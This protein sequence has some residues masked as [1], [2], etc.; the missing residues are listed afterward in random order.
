MFG[1][2]DC[3]NFFVSCERLFRPD[4]L[5]KPVAVLSSNDG[6]IVARSQEVKDL[7]IPMGVPYFQVKDVLTKAGATLFSSNFTLYRDISA[8]VMSTLEQEVGLC[9]IYSIDEAF[10]ELPDD[11]TQNEVFAIRTAVMNKVGIPVSIG[12]AATKTLAKQGS[13]L[14]KQQQGVC[15]L[16]LTLWQTI[17]TE[18]PCGSIW[19]IGRQTAVK[20]REL[21]VTSVAEF[22]KLDLAVVRSQFGVVGERIK[23]ELSGATVFSLGESH[24]EIQQ[25]IMST[26]SFEH[27]TTN[28]AELQSALAYHVEA[29]AS[30]LREKQLLASQMTIMVLPSRH[31]DFFLKTGRKEI[32]F[33][34][35]TANTQ[36]LLHEALRALSVVYEHGVP[37]KKAG[38]IV[39][40]LSPQMAATQSLFSQAAEETQHVLDQMRDS[41]N[42]RFGHGTI[43]SAV[44]LPN[45]ARGSAKLR[46]KEYTTKWK[47]IPTV[48]AK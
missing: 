26:R 3:N 24:E 11:I 17:A 7:D 19:G 39:G 2:L 40:G 15:V 36:D 33:T 47:D 35:P 45:G 9:E 48:H 41:L 4:L 14:A 29:V 42:M 46:S 18:I 27:T 13:K 34:Q 30:K 20:L 5:K 28:R 1:L 6:C 12:V 44:I 22:L 43:Q 38:V 21:G 10:F 32:I 16:D 37:Y 31:G 8:R 23:A 25:S